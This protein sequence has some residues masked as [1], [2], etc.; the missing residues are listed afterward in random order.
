MPDLAKKLAMKLTS[1]VKPSPQS[2]A[3]SRKLGLDHPEGRTAFYSSF[4]SS[5]PASI[6]QRL[7]PLEPS[8]KEEL[9]SRLTNNRLL[10]NT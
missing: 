6:A 7:E 3:I 10:E 8:V 2:R 9:A 5:Y 4:K 1:P